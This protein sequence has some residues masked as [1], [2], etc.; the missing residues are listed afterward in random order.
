MKLE[1]PMKSSLAALP[2]A[3][4][5]AFASLPSTAAAAGPEAGRFSFSL[6]GE[7]DTPLSGDVHGGAVAP[8]PNLGPLNP[9]LNG[10]SAELRIGSRGWD[11]IYGST[12]GFGVEIAYGLGDSS[13]VF[14][15]VRRN[16]ADPG[17]ERVGG[18]FVPAL[19]AELDV[20][21]T[22]SRYRTTALEVGYRH[23]FM[24]P[25]YARPFV[26]GR[27]GAVRTDDITATFEIPAGGIRISDAPFYDRD[28]SLTAGA[29]LGVLVPITERFSVQAQA[30]VRYIDGLSGDD[31]AI[32][33]LGLGSI[34][35]DGERTSYPIS[36][37]ARWVF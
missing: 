30:G 4:A 3:A 27:L 36:V 14:G 2:L 10:V 18:A 1:P 28:T 11:Q 7:Y 31:S 26:A 24:E 35:D 34:N 37:Q 19:N 6:L 33:G 17:R 21:G 22:F 20:F 12:T 13:E 25:G 15:I 9:A 5:M 32:G 29:D 16:E 8:V 23:F